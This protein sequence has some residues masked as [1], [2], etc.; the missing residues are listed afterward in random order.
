MS[1][2]VYTE[3]HN[4]KISK[5]AIEA[6]SYASKLATLLGTT[7]TALVCGEA[8]DAETLGQVGIS[9]ILQVTSGSIS[10]FDTQKLS[11][12]VQ[13]AVQK[14]KAT[15]IVF[16]HD[17]SGKAIA[18]RVA[19][20]L[21]AGLVAGAVSLPD[22]SSGFIV[23][24]AVFSGKAFAHVSVTSEVKVISL[25][26]NSFS[27]EKTGGTAS[28]ESFSPETGK[29]GVTVKEIRKESAK[30]SL[31]EADLVVSAGRGMKGPE[32]WGNIEELATLMGA[33]T[34][35][36]RPVADIGWRPHHEHVGQTGLAIRPNLYIAVGISGAIQHLAGVNGSKVI[37]VINTDAEAPFFKAADY[38]IVGD[39][40]QVL[41]KLI[42]AYKQFKASNN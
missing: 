7:A 25:L 23:K 33:A 26:P 5:N 24:K 32:N 29:A 31:T 42:E 3:P 34:A 37:V 13:E 20:K 41:P 14:E 9:K 16:S 2:L 36:S 10:Q 6:A 40:F 11:K 27:V 18:P 22:T 35:C 28:I 4:E 12:A 17:F 1:V 8:G 38:G 39:A 30:L 19:A 15:V 21:G